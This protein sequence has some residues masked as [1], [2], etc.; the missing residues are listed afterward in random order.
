MILFGVLIAAVLVSLAVVEAVLQP[1]AADR[2]ALTIM[3]SS[4]ALVTAA[5]GWTVPRWTASLRSFRSGVL[6]VVISSVDYKD[7]RRF[8]EALG[9]PWTCEAAFGGCGIE[10]RLSP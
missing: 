9:G 1:A 7:K 6:V 3:F 8:G 4:F 2:I 5:V 10:P